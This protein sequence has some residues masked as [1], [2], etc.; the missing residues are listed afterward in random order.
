MVSYLTERILHLCYKYQLVFQNQMVQLC[1]YQMWDRYC[2]VR[3]GACM[4]SHHYSKKYYEIGLKYSCVLRLAHRICGCLK[5]R[6][7]QRK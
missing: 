5:L 6:P 4:L 3:I 1:S 7:H 2:Y